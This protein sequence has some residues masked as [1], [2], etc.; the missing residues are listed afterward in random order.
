MLILVDTSGSVKGQT[1]ELLVFAVKSLLDTL[2]DNDYVHVARFPPHEDQPDDSL[3]IVNCF[4]SFVQV[5]P[6]FGRMQI[7]FEQV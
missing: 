4:S 3:G 2:D 6:V 5:S 1:L 7:I